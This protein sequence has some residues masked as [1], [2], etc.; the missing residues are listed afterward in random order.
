[1][2]NALTRL[3][4]GLLSCCPSYACSWLG[5]KNRHA[6]HHS[7]LPCTWVCHDTE[8][9]HVQDQFIKPS[10][11]SSSNASFNACFSCPFTLLLA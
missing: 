11:M 1:M 8:V 10:D 7:E 4:M 3:M 9:S 6:R 2:C 5:T